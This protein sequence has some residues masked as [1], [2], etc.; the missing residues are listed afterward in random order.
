VPLRGTLC[1]R[2]PWRF[3]AVIPQVWI[4]PII[5]SGS[6]AAAYE[7]S[8]LRSMGTGIHPGLLPKLGASDR[9]SEGEEEDLSQMGSGYG[10]LL[11]VI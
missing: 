3:P 7:A 5:V 10:A 8:T 2:A 9:D 11:G 6:H 4:T 1:H